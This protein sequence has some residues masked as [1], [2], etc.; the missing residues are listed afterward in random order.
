[1]NKAIRHCLDDARVAYTDGNFGAT[2]AKLPKAPY[3]RWLARYPERNGLRFQGSVGSR[4]ARALTFCAAVSELLIRIATG[5]D[6][7]GV[8][9]ARASARLLDGH[10]RESPEID[11]LAATVVR[12]HEK[13]AHS[14]FAAQAQRQ[15]GPLGIEPSLIARS[16]AV[17]ALRR[18][19]LL[20]ARLGR[21]RAKPGEGASHP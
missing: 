7:F 11:P 13:T 4:G 10:A 8:D 9:L 21:S 18:H 20:E 6:D 14:P 17:G 12:R 19:E 1:M 2:S 5:C 16:A 3:G 15:P